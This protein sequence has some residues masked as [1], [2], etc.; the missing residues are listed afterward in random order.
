MTGFV[1]WRSE[2][3]LSKHGIFHARKADEIT[4]GKLPL[5]PMAVDAAAVRGVS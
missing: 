2:S 4:Y 1:I 3:E 5:N